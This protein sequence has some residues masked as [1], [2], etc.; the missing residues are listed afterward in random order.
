M[1]FGPRVYKNYDPRAKII[2]SRGDELLKTLNVSDPLLDIA[3][4]LEQAAL[5]DRYFVERPD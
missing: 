4:R 1:G 3:L 5:N 2:K